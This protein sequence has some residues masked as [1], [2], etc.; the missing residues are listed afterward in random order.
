MFDVSDWL[1]TES[2][3]T[4]SVTDTVSTLHKNLSFLFKQS[5]SWIGVSAIADLLVK[6]ND[7]D[8]C[9]FVSRV[10]LARLITSWDFQAPSY[11][12]Q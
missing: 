12:L 7:S 3:P 6:Y 2:L 10:C 8:S 4:V 1:D 9:E 5:R 11:T